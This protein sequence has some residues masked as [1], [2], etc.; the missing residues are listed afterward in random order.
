MIA[1]V[2]PEY[3]FHGIHLVLFYN[4]ARNIFELGYEGG[5]IGWV[6]EGNTPVENTLRRMG[7]KRSKTYNLYR[8]NL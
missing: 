8:I 4:I 7:A 6:M 3:R 1:G 5:E 2:L